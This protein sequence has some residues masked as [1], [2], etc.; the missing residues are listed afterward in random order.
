MI[1]G[2]FRIDLPDFQRFTDTSCSKPLCSGCNVFSKIEENRFS[3]AR[4]CKTPGGVF[5]R[6]NTTKTAGGVAAI[7]ASPIRG[8]WAGRFSKKHGARRACRPHPRR[9]FPPKNPGLC[10]GQIRRP[11]IWQPRTRPRNVPKRMLRPFWIKYASMFPLRPNLVEVGL[12]RGQT[13]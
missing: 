3:A 11:G 10:G 8:H 5:C 13:H 7:I 6:E 2:I 9:P 1:L 4:C 12:N